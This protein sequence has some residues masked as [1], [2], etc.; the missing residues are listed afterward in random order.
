M[1]AKDE[2]V[3]VQSRNARLLI[4][5]YEAPKTFGP[6][7]GYAQEPLLPLAD[8]CAPLINIVHNI[9]KHVSIALKHTLHDPSDGLTR[10]E[11]AAIR[12]YT[13]E[14]TGGHR[15]L[16]F[17]LNKTLETADREHLRPW[18]KYLKLFLTALA[19][20]EC[21]PLQTVWRGVRKDISNEFPPGAQVTWWN[22]S[23]CTTTL[24]VLENNLY[25]GRDG[26]RTLFSIEAFNGRNIRAHS[27]YDVEDEV[28]L[29]PG[30]YMEVQ[31]QF[32]PAPDLH[33]IHLRQKI[34]QETL[35]EPPFDGCL[36]S[37]TCCF[38]LTYFSVLGAFLYPAHVI[39]IRDSH[40]TPFSVAHSSRPTTLP[41]Y[42]KK[43]II[44][45]ICLVILACLLAIILGA[46]LGSRASA[47][48]S[49]MFCDFLTELTL[50]YHYIDQILHEISLFRY[51]IVLYVDLLC[52]LTFAPM[53]PYST[54]SKQP[55][56][57]TVGDFNND[58]L[59]DI[60]VAYH[61]GG[62]V[63]IFLG[64]GNGSFADQTLFPAGYNPWSVIAADFNNDDRL[65]IA[66]TNGK[67]GSV[68]VLLGYGNGSFAPQMTF[69]T[70]IDPWAIAVGDFN[71]D[72]RLDIA[73]A[74]GR[75][76]TTSILLGYGN[77]SFAPQTTLPTGYF[78][79]T[80]NV[81]DFNNDTNL[82]IV[83]VNSG[84]YNVGIFLGYGNGT[85]AAQTTFP[86]GRQP[87]WIAIGDLN[88]DSQ[89]DIVVT[90][91]LDNSV[92]VLLGYGNGTFANQTT[93]P[94]GDNPQAVS[95]NDFNRDNKSDIIVANYGG[96]TVSI[97]LGYGNGS[98]AMQRTFLANSNPQA[99]TTG[100]F[101]ADKQPDMAVAN[102]GSNNV[103]IFLN[104]C[105]CCPS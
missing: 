5:E 24:N 70:G 98:F 95:F 16:Y 25:L 89:S 60:A 15:S 39:D 43:W 103:G 11:S 88:N 53:M 57:V 64:Y 31:S 63:G 18:Y 73:A 48:E 100:D 8:A 85:F 29:L 87:N 68:G 99:I 22:F 4:D 44:I 46:V 74:N 94:T 58:S 34:P 37:F 69:A 27:N 33:V 92:S 13:M 23:S 3:D 12:L 41:W 38:N 81:G 101:N 96:G 26:P 1:P 14:W 30:T 49:G 17:I 79:V 66:V 77:G 45:S 10:D 56:S 52:R 71:H 59:P 65:D 28:L 2:D 50:P 83:V 36:S 7:I 47:S 91:R 105:Y 55:D 40:P 32:S 86:T 54:G 9:S 20:M 19:R 76:N 80:L 35:C 61:N 75:E 97:L 42:R 78:A 72:N 51:I 62:N 67:E 82:D 90:N 93:F 21:V 102:Y 84:D 6:V 104:T